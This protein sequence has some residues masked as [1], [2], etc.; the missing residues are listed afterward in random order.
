[1]HD[2]AVPN[3]AAV[4]VLAFHFLWEN[5]IASSEWRQVDN[6]ES[7]HQRQEEQNSVMVPKILIFVRKI[8]FIVN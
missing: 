6:F 1:M 7:Q 4:V 8:P 2:G 5:V 3:A